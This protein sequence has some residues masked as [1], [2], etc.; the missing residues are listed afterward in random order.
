LISILS[1]NHLSLVDGADQGAA[2]REVLSL[3]NL[4]SD[5][6]SRVMIEG[7][8]SIESRRV[9]GRAGGAAAGGFCRG[10]E[11][12]LHLDEENFSGGGLYLFASV[13]DRFLGLYATINS[14]VRT[15][16]ATQ[17]R[18]GLLCQWPPR[19]GEQVLV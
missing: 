19:C 18:D 7:L 12:T 1:L 11:V 6:Q 9:V 4:Q 2:L 3:Y 15:R 16:V 8:T 10:V 5:S 17:Q 14:F 13:L